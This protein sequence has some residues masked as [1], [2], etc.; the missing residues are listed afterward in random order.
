MGRTSTPLLMPFPKNTF[1]TQI[2]MNVRVTSPVTERMRHRL[3]SI[4]VTLQAHSQTTITIKIAYSRTTGPRVISMLLTT[5]PKL[6]TTSGPVSLTRT[7]NPL[8]HER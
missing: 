5:V 3:G 8:E 6:S 4:A 1:R 7:L 2:A